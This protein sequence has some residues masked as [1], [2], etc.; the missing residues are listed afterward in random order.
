MARVFTQDAAKRL[1]LPGRSSSEILSGKDG[2]PSV[3]LRLVEIPTPG[4]SD[5]HRTPHCHKQFE[6]CIFVLSGHGITSA[7][8]GDHEIRAGDTIWIAPGEMHMT[9]NT[10]AETLV[11]LCFFP[12]ANV[13]AGTQET[14]P[15]TQL[16]PDECN[17]N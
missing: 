5:S 4:P 3:T 9:R 17:G 2:L 7:E 12:I 10:G 1:T 14:P 16:S 8:N 6:E 13:S 11:L 15:A